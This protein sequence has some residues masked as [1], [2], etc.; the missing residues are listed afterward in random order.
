MSLDQ[1]LPKAIE[2][3]S[4]RARMKG[5]YAESRFQ[6]HAL[7]ADESGLYRGIRAAVAAS[8]IGF[9][10]PDDE[11]GEWWLML[12]EAQRGVQIFLP[13]EPAPVVY[14]ERKKGRK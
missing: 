11:K 2:W 10:V 3:Y 14:T 6:V 13:R 4:R 8:L 1:E 12:S 7:E 5:Y 9:V